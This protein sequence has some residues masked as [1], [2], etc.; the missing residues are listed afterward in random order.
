MTSQPVTKEVPVIR[1]L[2]SLLAILALVVAAC[3]GTQTPG[4]SPSDTIAF[5]DATALRAALEN[6]NPD[7][8]GGLHVVPSA[9]AQAGLTERTIEILPRCYALFDGAALTPSSA[10]ALGAPLGGQTCENYPVGKEKPEGGRIVGDEA[11]AKSLWITSETTNVSPIPG[12]NMAAAEFVLPAKAPAGSIWSRV[13]II[14]A[15]GE[16]VAT[17]EA[18]ATIVSPDL[19]SLKPVSGTKIPIDLSSIDVGEAAIVIVQLVWRTEDGLLR[20]MVAYPF[21]YVVTAPVSLD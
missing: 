16:T 11:G 14:K 7:L 1:P 19:G 8:Y 17:P 13:V 3:G 21:S 6:D 20:G 18:L 4:E 5:T 15:G 2:A 9:G 10:L 12:E